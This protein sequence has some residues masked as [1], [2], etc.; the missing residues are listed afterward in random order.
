MK[1]VTLTVDG[2]KLT[3]PEGT[4]IIDACE[5]N[6]IYIPRFCYH[7]HLTKSGNC[8]MCLVKIERNPKP[9]PSCMTPVA[10]GMI[11]YTNTPEIAQMRKAML[12]FILINHPLDCPICDKA[13][14]CMLQDN[15]LPAMG[16]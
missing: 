11:V 3:V 14:E 15:A 13:G 2:K 7:K 16:Q 6:G 10:E 12:E 9:Q 8:R 4:L 5:Q 1:E